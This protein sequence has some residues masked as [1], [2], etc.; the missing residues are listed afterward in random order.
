M[1]YQIRYT[2]PNTPFEILC[3]CD[4]T[5]DVHKQMEY[6]MTLYGSVA[7]C[8]VCDSPARPVVIKGDIKTGPNAGKKATY[9]K[10]WCENMDCKAQLQ[11]HEY[12][13]EQSGKEGL[14]RVSEEKFEVYQGEKSG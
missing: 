11:V 14:Y 9:Y 8:S 7:T 2:V 1:S 12:Y 3:S 13:K 5:T 10:W 4:T 6:L